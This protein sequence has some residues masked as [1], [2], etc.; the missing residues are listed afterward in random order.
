MNF[1][2][3]TIRQRVELI[4][5]QLNEQFF[6]ENGYRIRFFVEHMPAYKDFISGQFDMFKKLTDSLLPASFAAKLSG[7]V[8]PDDISYE[9]MDKF[10]AE[11]RERQFREKERI[12]T[13]NSK[14]QEGNGDQTP[15]DPT[16]D[17]NMKSFYE[18]VKKFRKWHK[19][20]KSK[21][22][23]SEFKSDL[24]TEQLKEMLLNG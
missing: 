15:T 17:N 11:E 1:L 4:Q 7:I 2:K 24:L 22:D 16:E 9:D 23:L 8:L 3:Y 10:V 6:I 14:I 13:L 5:N 21:K 20:N 18:E 19:N 12:V